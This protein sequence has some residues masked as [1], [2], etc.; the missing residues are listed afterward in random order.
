MIQLIKYIKTN[1]MPLNNLTVPNL[2][3]KEE[4]EKENGMTFTSLKQ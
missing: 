1:K 4:E 3:S 2:K